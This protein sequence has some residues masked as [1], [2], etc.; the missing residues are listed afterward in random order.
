MKSNRSE[1]PDQIDDE[2]L[3]QFLQDPTWVVQ[4]KYRG[5][6]RIVR[7]DGG[8]AIGIDRDGAVVEL[9][10]ALAEALELLAGL[11]PLTLDGE[12]RGDALV[13]FDLLEAGGL[14][15]RE[16]EYADRLRS[17]ERVIHPMLMEAGCP[18]G[19]FVGH[20]A[21]TEADKRAHFG[22]LKAEGVEGAVFK[23]MHAP[24][25]DQWPQSGGAQLVHR[26]RRQT[27]H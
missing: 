4:E 26:F 7:F 3:E 13:A 25:P 5:D 17:L 15:L 19:L 1:L 18:A 12:L 22:A 6:R 10:Q 14:D 24:C 27:L 9:P 11:A 8:Q 16:C 23:Q 2:D 21:Q 20:T